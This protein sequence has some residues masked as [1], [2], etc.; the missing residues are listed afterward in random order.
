MSEHRRDRVVAFEPRPG[1]PVATVAAALEAVADEAQ[2]G[3]ASRSFRRMSPTS[4]T[5]VL[6]GGGWVTSAEL[7]MPHRNLAD[8]VTGLCP[9]F[10]S[11]RP[12]SVWEEI[13]G[14]SPGARPGREEPS[15]PLRVYHADF[16][17]NQEI[18]RLL[19]GDAAS[20]VALT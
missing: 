2:E 16:F 4:L 3:E 9:S 5:C 15:P 20:V 1:I 13:V 12:G 8:R 11:L 6:V 10:T 7:N 18:C 14:A 17:P 19:V